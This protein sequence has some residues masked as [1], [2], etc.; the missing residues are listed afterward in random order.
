MVQAPVE[1]E[2]RDFLYHLFVA[3]CRTYLE[4]KGESAELGPPLLPAVAHLP[5]GHFLQRRQMRSSAA[6][7][8]SLVVQA[9]RQLDRLRYLQTHTATLAAKATLGVVEPSWQGASS[10]ALQPVAYPEAVAEFR[11]FLQAVALEVHEGGGSMTIGIDELDKIGTAD[12]AH[13]FLNELKAVFG[14]QHCHFLVSVSEDALSEFEL[15]GIPV[16]TAFDSSFDEIVSVDY[17]PFKECRELLSRRVIGLAEPFVCF[18]YCLSGGLPR[19]LIRACRRMIAVGRRRQ[20]PTAL[21]E[22]CQQMIAEELAGKATAVRSNLAQVRLD[23]RTGQALNVARSAGLEPM[24]LQRGWAVLDQMHGLAKDW[25]ADSRALA[26][27]RT[28]GTVLLELLAYV[29]Y[30]VTLLEF[31]DSSLG[32]ERVVRA[33]DPASGGA[34]LDNLASARQAFSVDPQLVWQ[35]IGSFREAWN[36]QPTPEYPGM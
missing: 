24:T 18:C 30:C 35:G 3:L 19:D 11:R 22:L 17:L 21:P 15:R 25:L 5:W 16:R 20:A 33:V 28:C 13:R 34:S 10:F 2:A 14:I 8:R 9:R 27:G 29:Y 6:P 7:G 36:L 31:F 4:S 23:P 32:R 12:R 26:D 1:Y